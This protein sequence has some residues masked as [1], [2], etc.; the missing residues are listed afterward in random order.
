MRFFTIIGVSLL[1]LTGCA[2]NT[3]ADD[4]KSI[5]DNPD[6]AFASDYKPNPDEVVIS[7]RLISFSDN[8]A[9]VEVIKQLATG[10]GAKAVLS[11]GDELSLSTSSKPSDNFICAFEVADVPGDN[12]TYRITRFLK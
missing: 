9:K 7:A 12:S 10:F 4:S 2:R 6:L 3:A 5:V 11:P 1:L 8:V